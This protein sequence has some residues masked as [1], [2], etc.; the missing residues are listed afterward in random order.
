MRRT[1]ILLGLLL[2]PLPAHAEIV[3]GLLAIRGAEMS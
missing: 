3:K 2:L 1:A